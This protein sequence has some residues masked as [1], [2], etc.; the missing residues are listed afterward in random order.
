MSDGTDQRQR[1][2]AAFAR[3]R[4]QVDG[5]T[6][7]QRV[8]L[9]AGVAERLRFVDLD[10][11]E[12]GT[13]LA[14]FE[15]DATFVLARIA[16]FNR[17][18]RQRDFQRVFASAPP[19]RLA[20]AVLQ[21]AQQIDLWLHQLGGCTAP[22][23]LA[24]RVAIEQRIDRQLGGQLDW[25][26]SQFGALAWQGDSLGALCEGL[27]A[28]WSQPHADTLP[29]AQQPQRQSLRNVCFSVLSAM[30]H[31]QRLAREQLAATLEGKAHEPAAGLLLVFLRLYETVAQQINGFA[32][33]HVDFYYQQ[34]LGL[35]AGA[36]QAD[37]VH[38]A[39][40]RDARS[41]LDVVVPVGSRFAAGKDAAGVPVSFGA[42]QSLALNEA[43]VA[44]LCTLLLERDDKISPES[45]L[46]YVTG[47]R[48]HWLG[49]P[50]DDAAPVPLFGGG[51]GSAEAALGLVVA[52]PVLLLQE[53]R[54]EIRLRLRLA[55][56]ERAQET[57]LA[58]VL[59]TR[60]APALRAALGELFACWMLDDSRN[61]LADEQ[62]RHALAQH[63]RRW[64][65]PL[66][67]PESG[68]GS[69]LY[70]MCQG[71][72]D[73]Y[74]P[75]ELAFFKYV[76]DLFDVSLTHAAGW[77]DARRIQI[78]RAQPGSG[79][80]AGLQLTIYL[81]QDDPAIV[82]CDPEV[83]GT[84]WPTRLPLLRLQVSPRARIYPLSL[85][86]G[87]ELKGVEL[88]VKVQGVRALV[89]RNNLGPL[90]ASKPFAPFGPLPTTS[91]YLDFGSPEAAGKN[92]SALTLHLSWSALPSE[93]G[94]F[95]AHYAAY[96]AEQRDGPFT[97]A[98]SI[99]R[100]GEWRPCAGLSA[101]QPLFA[102]PDAQGRLREAHRIEVDSASVGAHARASTEALGASALV[103]DGLVRLQLN[104]PRGAFGHAAYA[105]LLSRAVTS[106][107]RKRGSTETPQAPYTPMVERVSVDYEARTLIS[108]TPERDPAPAGDA[109]RLLHIHP[110]GVSELR[111]DPDARHHG[112]LPPLGPDG[113]VCDGNLCIGLQAGAL[114]GPLSLLFHLK[115]QSIAQD[116]DAPAAHPAAPTRP[117]RP[118]VD[119]F[120]LAHNR[121][122]ALEPH[123]VLADG[124]QGFLDSG[125]VT[126]DLQD[127]RRRA[128]ADGTVL[129]TG[130]FWLRAGT[131][132]A[133]GRV[134]QLV[135]VHA[136]A[137][138]LTRELDP[139][140]PPQ[141]ALPAQSI[142]QADNA[143]PGLAGVLQAEPSTG[144]RAAEDERQL[145]VRAGE[146]LRHKNRA[147][148]AWD[149]ERLVLEHFPEVFKAKCFAAHEIPS[150][151]GQDA[152]TVL[153][154]VVPHVRRNEP[155]D[156]TLAPQLHARALQDIESF[157]AQRASPFAR[158]RVRNATY[159]RVQAR[160]ALELQPGVQAGAVLR[161]VNRL[162]THTL[163]PWFDEGYGPVFEWVLRCD[164]IESKVR[165]VPGVAAVGQLSLLRVARADDGLY[166]FSDTA[167]PSAGP[168]DAAPHE[169]AAADGTT[170]RFAAPWSLA[171]PMAEHIVE[172]P[173]EALAKTA[174]PTGLRWLGVGH[175]MVIAGAQHDRA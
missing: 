111:P 3:E 66:D 101:R 98:L 123:Q 59:A 47:V 97:A 140:S 95:A 82:G 9:C 46:G 102:P 133:V 40:L 90:D 168:S 30:A 91:S 26:R 75:R 162:L 143:V 32:D 105:Y 53:G 116:S 166:T 155:E 148:L 5:M 41:E 136:N 88:G 150:A 132:T 27:H 71:A 50:E 146:R 164:D 52:S 114:D 103:R 62:H 10:D 117:W 4:F 126:L 138:T 70:L 81:R 2:P 7:A 49:L 35:R 80:E 106:R 115:R 167:R 69:P 121:W 100:D 48:S 39:C 169:A 12:A 172:L 86:Q 152:G 134:A 21:L 141:Q 60:S 93:P 55:W 19:A 33:R 92:L 20:H 145:R 73:E 28:A 144:L 63:A 45:D 154:A 36:A 89:L 44:A 38:V 57:L 76:T 14:L 157:L 22:A 161:Q 107:T 65:G 17:Q 153:V 119:W 24:V 31:V 34:V 131:R 18:Q 137:L 42:T 130:L 171:L 149:V 15:D 113:K 118:Q 94:G 127:L 16:S 74:E 85:L 77:L 37:R 54:R 6:L 108:P 125:V 56:P 29:A 170:L 43:R 64:L 83:H 151:A 159:E 129:P 173:A 23:A 99:L 158:V 156:A 104:H 109:E 51:A 124:T 61:L 122:C 139:A 110:F 163:S 120:Y 84:Q 11:R 147:S 78:G 25:L 68:V 165:D 174:E 72:R 87:A 67:E 96:G 79:G 8:A 135:T 175:T 58:A 142:T 160:C 128:D 13:W 112:L 1:L